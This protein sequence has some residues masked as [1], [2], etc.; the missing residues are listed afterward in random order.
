MFDIVRF[1]FDFEIPLVNLSPTYIPMNMPRNMLGNAE[2]DRLHLQ[3]ILQASSLTV[4][5][6]IFPNK[7]L[8]YHSLLKSHMR[9]LSSVRLTLNSLTSPST[10]STGQP[11]PSMQSTWNLVAQV[12][13]VAS[14]ST[15]Y[16]LILSLGNLAGPSHRFIA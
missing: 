9:I 3:N 1:S 14:S 7:L 12:L 10:L 16:I 5:T 4:A 6:S 2:L 11:Q 13:S 8:P 15:A